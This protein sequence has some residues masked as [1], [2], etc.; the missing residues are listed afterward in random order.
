MSNIL[1]GI[2]IKDVEKQLDEDINIVICIKWKIVQLFY[3]SYIYFVLIK[4][5]TD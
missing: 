1:K 5:Y 4:T 2:S 3:I